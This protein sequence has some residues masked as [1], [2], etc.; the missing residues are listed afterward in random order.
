MSG[1][2]IPVDIEQCEARLRERRTALRS[3]LLAA[4]RASAGDDS[5]QP[6]TEVHDW[7]DDAFA[8]L[9]A[10]L[11]STELAHQREELAA[12]QTALQRIGAG[13]F[14]DCISCGE[15]IGRERL[16]VQPSAARCLKCQERA[17]VPAAPREIAV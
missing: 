2:L 17:E 10:N 16:L 13:R 15:E 3:E 1:P 7:K 14:G 8:E 12:V 4:A 5:R 6:A 11:R 9:V